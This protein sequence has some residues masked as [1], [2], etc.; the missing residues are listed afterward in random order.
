MT[1][2]ARYGF[3]LKSFFF[4]SNIDIVRP[5]L[6]IT[7]SILLHHSLV[8]RLISGQES[9]SNSVLFVWFVRTKLANRKRKRITVFYSKQTYLPFTRN[10]K[11]FSN[12]W[13]N[14][15]NTQFN[16]NLHIVIS[17]SVPM[18]NKLC[19]CLPCIVPR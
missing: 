19:F 15:I 3:N 11:R 8:F 12:V 9:L 1:G 16:L 14:L 2:C 17:S 6:S 13:R 4:F 7:F 10:L 18:L 5:L